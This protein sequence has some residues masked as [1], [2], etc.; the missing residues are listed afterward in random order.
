MPEFV[1]HSSHLDPYE[2]DVVRSI[3]DVPVTKERL[4]FINSVASDLE[5]AGTCQPI[6]NSLNYRLTN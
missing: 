4:P 5:H 2:D 6:S 1:R 3:E